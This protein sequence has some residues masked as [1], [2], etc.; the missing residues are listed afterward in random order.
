MKLTKLIML[1]ILIPIILTDYLQN[2][3]TETPIY[4][5]PN[6]QH[7]ILTPTTIIHPIK[8]CP[9]ASQLRCQPCG[10]EVS[11]QTQIDCPCAPRLNCPKC[12]PLSLI[13]EIASKKV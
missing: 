10:L 3:P 9:C 5:I 4:R 2:E 7:H 12:P 6:Q 11:P 1:K 8:I 13:H